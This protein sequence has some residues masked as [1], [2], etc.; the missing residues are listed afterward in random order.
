MY[1]SYDPTHGPTHGP[2]HDLYVATL[3]NGAAIACDY[4]TSAKT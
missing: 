2:A 3:E 1:D 4:F